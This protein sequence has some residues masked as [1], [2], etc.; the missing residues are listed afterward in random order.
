MNEKSEIY[1]HSFK[2]STVRN[3]ELTAPYMHN[4]VYKNLEQV[5]DFYNNGG[6][7]GI[8]LDVP[9]QTLPQDSL[10]LSSKEK[11]Q[12][13]AFMRSLTDTTDLT[14]KPKSLPKFDDIELNKRKIGG[15]Y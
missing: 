11:N 6:G 8:G 15:N 3:I 5:I 14:N 4:G 7:I 1:L 9:N 13:I 2:T 12:I 10:H